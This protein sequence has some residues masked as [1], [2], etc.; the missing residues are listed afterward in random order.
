MSNGPNNDLNKQ[1]EIFH[2]NLI[3]GLFFI[4][5]CSYICLHHYWAKN[6]FFGGEIDP[7]TDIVL[8][9]IGA[10]FGIIILIYNKKNETYKANKIACYICAAYCFLKLLFLSLS[11]LHFQK[12]TE[13]KLVGIKLLQNGLKAARR[14]PQFSK[15]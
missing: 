15:R 8:A 11:C 13:V 5:T 10:L 7:I 6:I 1:D 9:G 4:Y 14:A 2:F 12:Q 3:Q